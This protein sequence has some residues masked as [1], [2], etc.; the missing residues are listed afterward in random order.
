MSVP[1]LLPRDPASDRF[2]ELFIAFAACGATPAGGVHR[3]CGSPADGEARAV[4]DLA[5]RQAGGTVCIDAV[6]NQYGVFSLAP[7]DDAPL[8]MFGSHLD[9][10][11][12]GGRFD[13]ALGVAAALAVGEALIADKRA[14]ADFSADFCA[15]NWTNEEGARFR[16][17]LLG[18]G[19][20]AGR[21]DAAYA[22]A[23]TDDDDVS[24]GEA[25][26]AIGQS[27]SDA[28]PKMPACYLELHVEQGVT[29]E[30]AGV[31]LGIVRRN[32]GA[33]KF[34]IRFDGE[35]A[36]TGPTPMPRRRDALLAAAYLIAEIR[37][38]A[39]RWPGAVHSSV[40]RLIVRPNSS[41]VV[42]SEVSL[43]AEIRAVEDG[44]LREAG[45][46]A[47]QAVRDAAARAGVAIGR[48]ERADRPGRPLPGEVRDLVV[49]CANAL[50]LPHIELDTVSGHDALSLLG[51]C[52]TGLVFVPSAGGI[53]HSEREYTAP[54]AME[55]GF[56]V[57]LEAALR[58]CRSDGVAERAAQWN[59]VSVR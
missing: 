38:V 31:P 5:V 23:R 44:I 22:L 53:A 17:S 16:P 57:L 46:L 50:G 51:L 45:A 8:V 6:G 18:S 52:P 9:S 56:C 54:D 39:D 20:F 37:A 13:G 30:Q 33:A 55:A 34:D 7:Q 4:F 11:P 19:F 58:L 41:N 59:G 3:L 2:H 49:A 24:L 40:G 12:N 47:A 32:W 43:S 14:G 1:P 21:H 27:G 26:A 29:L 42:P 35:P 48:C 36:H 15:V 28:P 10:Q 25:L